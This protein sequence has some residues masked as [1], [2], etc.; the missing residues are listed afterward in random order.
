EFLSIEVPDIE[1]RR[2]I[3]ISMNPQ[4][5]DII[6][7]D[8]IRLPIQFKYGLAKNI[9]LSVRPV[10]YIHNPR[11]K[12]VGLGIADL[13][14]GI[15]YRFLHIL[16]R[17]VSMAFAFHTIYPV[18][19]NPELM[20]GYVHYKPRLIVSKT[21]EDFHKLQVVSS[22]GW[23]LID[24]AS[25]PLLVEDEVKKDIT[26]LSFGLR[27]PRDPFAWSLEFVYTTDKPDNGEYEALTVTPGWHWNI[28]REQAEW[29]PG[30]L[31]LSLG[32]GFGFMDAKDV[33][34]ITKVRATIP[35]HVNVDLERGEVEFKSEELRDAFRK[36]NE[37]LKG[38]KQPEPGR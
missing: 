2:H 31:G 4:L 14:M 36:I 38:S 32:V 6:N 30:D 10:T 20:D 7:N 15:K 35:I 12:T 29:F 3:G 27:L 25:E 5:M 9:E 17:H 37:R 18:G 21:L 8:Y 16:R 24:G 1:R 34:Y 33:E 19:S 28:P 11:R 26:Q 23:N 22:I 13:D